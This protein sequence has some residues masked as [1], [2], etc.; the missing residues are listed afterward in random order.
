V[1]VA[2]LVSNLRQLD[3]RLSA[4]GGH[5]RVNAPKGVLTESLSAQ[6]A[7]RKQELLDFLRDN[8][9]PAAFNSFPVVRLKDSESAP[10]SF[11]QERLWFL[12][13]LEPGSAVYN[14]CRAWRLLGKLNVSAIEFSLNEIVRRHHV[15]RSSIRVDG[16]R[17]VQVVR[18][19]FELNLSVTNIEAVYL[20]GR[21]PEI[22]QRIRQAAEAPFDFTAGRFLRAELLRVADNEHVL[23]LATHHIVSD[24]WSMGILTRE[25]W[26]L[27]EAYANGRPSPLRELPVQYA[28]YAVWQREWLQGEVLERRLSYWKQRLGS[29]LPVLDLPTDHP[30]PVAQSFRGA[31]L[32]V[33][34]EESLTD[35]LAEL[36]RREGVT[37][38]MTLLAAFQTLLYRYTGQEEII[39]GSPIANRNRTEL[40][41]LIGFFVNTLLLRTDLSG[42]PTFRELLRRVRDVCLGAYAH[43]D[44]PFE[45]LVEELQP[46]R[47]LS[48]SPLFQVMFLLQNAPSHTPKLTGLSVG[49]IGVDTGTSKFD[50]TLGLAERDQKLVGFF[51]YNTDLFDQS[52][53]QRMAGHFE[54]L[55]QGIVANLDQPIFKLPLL[56]EAERHQLLVE[57]NDTVADYPKDS[58]IHELFEAQAEKTPE[59]IA[60][61]FDGRQLTYRELN[62]RANQLAHYLQRL[63]VGPEKLVG[64]CVE[65]SLEMVIGLLGVFKAGGAY[66]PLDPAYPRERLEFMLQDAQISVLLT[67]TK[68]VEDERW[69]PFLSETKGRDDSGLRSPVLGSQIKIVCL[70]ADWETVAR[71]SAQNVRSEVKPD[72]LAYV[73]YTSGSTGNP[74]GVAM[75]HRSLQN[76]ITWQLESLGIPRVARVLQFSSLSFDVSFQEIFSTCCSGGTLFLI[77]EALKHDPVGLLHEIGNQSIERLF[78]PFVVL[79]QLAEAADDGSVNY[80]SL[81]EIMTAG[82][83]LKITPQMRRFFYSLKECSFYN[84]YGPTETH[85]V[86][87][88]YLTGAPSEWVSRPPI[89]RPIA[90]T[91]LYILDSFYQPVPI[92]VHGE[93]YISGD[94]LA[95][96]YWNRA[97]LTAEKFITCSFSQRSRTRLYRTGDLARYLPNGDIEFLGRVDS[98]VKIRGYRVELGEIEAVLNQHPGIKESVV[99]AL[100]D[101]KD[102]TQET[103]SGIG[104]HRKELVAHI[105]SDEK[106]LEISELRNFLKQ[107]VPDYMIPSAF[108]FLNVLPLTPNGK[109]DRNA[110]RSP[111]NARPDL[112]EMYV[113]PRTHVE[114]LLAQIWEEVLKIEAVGIH[115]NFFE[116]GGHSLL[117]IQII[118]RV[119]EAVDKDLRLLALF[120]APTVAGLARTIEKTMSGRFQELPPIMPVPR[121]G[122]LSLSRNQEHLWRLDQMFPGNHFFNMPYVYR[123]TGQLDVIVLER[124]LEKLIKRHEALRTVFVEIDGRPVQIVKTSVDFRLP[125]VDLRSLETDEISDKA[126]GFILEERQDP[127]DLAV[128]PLIRIKLLCLTDDAY[129][130]LVTMHHIVS[131]EWSVR[132]FRRELTD[133]YEALSPGR[134]V[135]LREASIQ[136]ADFASWEVHLV[137]SGLLYKQ[138]VYWRK[139]LASPLS[140]LQF[141]K[142]RK[143]KRTLSFRTKRHAIDVDKNLS[144]AIKMLASKEQVTPFLVVL[145]ALNVLL[146]LCSGQRDIRIGTLVANRARKESE[147]MIGHLVNTV[148]L[149]TFIEGTMTLREVIEEV[150]R[151][152]HSALANQELPFEQLA[153]LLE[154][155]GIRRAS[156]FQVL[157]SYHETSF[158]IASLPGITFAPLGWK[159][160]GSIS[161]L[162]LTACDIVFNVQATATK[163]TGH[164]NY[165]TDT[166]GNNVV[167]GMIHR[168]VRILKRMTVDTG[169]TISSLSHL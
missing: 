54:R 46:K 72:N 33:T 92:G 44:L 73:I 24:A 51:E 106:Q 138:V 38:F 117:A 20:V 128:G 90:N 131:D 78:L 159:A 161:E 87:S 98:Q 70:D 125:I 158:E 120:E 168:F 26:I 15:L 132:V 7:E 63:G 16:S 32:S 41:E 103:E 143:G 28:D 160:P 9:A 155:D 109:V 52:T 39:V 22:R 75:A 56:T 100:S 37:L 27:Y 149:R 89:G 165:K 122:P 84:Q 121:N 99:V 114:E 74:K 40:E 153:R 83:Q 58:C 150:R 111:D 60:V 2:D 42:Q 115:D 113:E 50:L 136:C 67:Q 14:I 13:Q 29:N 119:R 144:I 169:T 4:E 77:P 18:P 157:L 154:G 129:L 80:T 71:E 95:R 140:E 107:K 123:I 133:L 53:T 105:V 110:L 97:E 17:P 8:K 36:S 156:L 101:L 162:M 139:Q 10:P 66:V 164:V 126:A 141:R 152:F 3:I 104:K 55:L 5:L 68:L 135:P 91:Q 167:A 93:L 130:L 86:T 82:E 76:L 137:E 142:A 147:G 57:W 1:S 30:R 23:I 6:I 45:K 21:E 35:A 69:K 11:A 65:R 145:S 31:R 112:K 85:V 163:L 62:T 81:K 61:Q 146:Y 96:G 102:E 34:F 134:A 166:F 127:F 43:Q 48:R 116:L 49:R 59:A 12:E 124:S 88:V 148:V 25:L 19:P 79:E 108:V 151:I 94:G 47:D 64:I 118:S